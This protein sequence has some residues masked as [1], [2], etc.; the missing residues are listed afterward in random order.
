MKI[1]IAITKYPLHLCPF[2]IALRKLP[3]EEPIASAAVDIESK[4]RKLSL[5][6]SETN[7]TEI[8]A[9]EAL[10][11]LKSIMP[12]IFWFKISFEFKVEYSQVRPAA[13]FR[14]PLITDVIFEALKLIPN[15]L[16]VSSAIAGDR[17]C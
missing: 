10:E 5:S 15:G 7:L 8:F 9:L 16:N 2:F 6:F 11:G 14:W 1:Y 12:L 4:S 13:F 3:G 17:K